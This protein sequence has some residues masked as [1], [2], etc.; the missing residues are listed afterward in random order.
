MRLIWTKNERAVSSVI[1][2]ITGEPVS[3]CALQYGP[4]IIHSNFLGVH[5]EWAP[6]FFKNTVVVY[7]ISLEASSENISKLNKTLLDTQF[8]FYDFGAMLYLGLKFFLRNH[9]KVAL[10]DINLWQDKHLF[11]CTEF[12]TKFYYGKSDSL[13]APFQLYNQIKEDMCG[14]ER[15]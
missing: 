9:F 10:P 12:I 3:H 14:D 6:A 2:M 13:V 15:K 1:R 4:F 7:E 5:I 8:H 11:T